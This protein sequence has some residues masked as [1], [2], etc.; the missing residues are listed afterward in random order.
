MKEKQKAETNVVDQKEAKKK[1]VLE[2]GEVVEGERMN[3]IKRKEDL[4]GEKIM[5]KSLEMKKK[6]VREDGETV[7]SVKWINGGHLKIE[8]MIEEVAEIVIWTVLVLHVEAPMEEDGD[9]MTEEMIDLHQIEMVIGEKIEAEEGLMIVTV[10]LSVV[11]LGGEEVKT[12]GVVQ[13]I[14]M[15]EV[16]I[17][18]IET[19]QC[20]EEEMIGVLA[21]IEAQEAMAVAL[22]V[23]MIVAHEEGMIVVVE[24]TE[25]HLTGGP[26]LENLIE[27]KSLKWEIVIVVMI[28]AIAAMVE[29]IIGDLGLE[30]ETEIE[31]DL[32]IVVHQQMISQKEVNN[33]QMGMMENG[34]LSANVNFIPNPQLVFIS[35]S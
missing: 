2:I 35:H 14:E 18:V 5:T 22:E 30:W 7:K 11:L 8:K 26:D 12:A 4:D 31:E 25:V 6:D 10:I 27:T 15:T 17:V 28:D 3:E 1:K 33:Q 16:Q 23:A 13:M 9:V 34:K 21:M 32:E 29:G 24:T 19:D 20:E